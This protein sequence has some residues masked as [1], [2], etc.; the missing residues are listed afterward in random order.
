MQIKPRVWEPRTEGAGVQQQ[1]TSFHLSNGKAL[2][3]Q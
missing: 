1:H 3:Q 2:K